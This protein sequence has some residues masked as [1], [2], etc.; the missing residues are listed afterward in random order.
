M[1]RTLEA[2]DGHAFAP[3]RAEDARQV[4]GAAA[5]DA[6]AATHTLTYAGETYGPD[7][8]HWPSYVVDD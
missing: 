7:G 4:L 2:L 1:P 8:Q 3:L 6:P 5:P